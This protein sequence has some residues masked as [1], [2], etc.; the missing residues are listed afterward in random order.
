MPC[1]RLVDR[2]GDR[3]HLGIGTR[4]EVEPM[5][6]LD[7]AETATPAARTPTK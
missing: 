4:L 1:R 2:C 5:A 6:Q 7:M 3:I